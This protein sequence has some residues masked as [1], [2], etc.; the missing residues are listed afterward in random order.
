MPNYSWPPM[1]SRKQIGKRYRRVDGI[2]KATGRAKY[3]SDLNKPGMLFAAM[4]TSPYA[5]AKVRS[6]DTSQ[7]EKMPGVTAVRVVAPAGTELQWVSQE[8]A[9]VSATSEE[10][11]RDAVR[12]I[13]VDYEVLP[14]VVR[15][16]D[17]SKVADRAKPAGEQVTGDPDKAFREAEVIS[18]GMYGIPV[19]THCCLEPHG[20]V[21]EWKGDQ[22]NYWPS[23]Q[24]VTNIGPD[25]AKNLGVPAT[26]V[27]VHMDHI[28]GGFGSKFP[29]DRWGV[30]CAN[31]S[32][33]SGG[34]PVKLFLD[35]ATELN[36]AGNRPSAFA[37]IRLAAKK[38]GTIIGWESSSWA[39]GGMSGG[40]MPP[41]PY[42]FVNIPNR[43]MNH[44]AVMTN[45]G[46]LR[47]WRAPNHP[48]ASFLTCSAIEDLA[49]KLGLDPM[50]V[51]AKNMQ[52]VA[53]ARRDSYLAQLKK[54][55]EMSEWSK[56]WHRRGDSGPGP[57]KRGMGIGICTW[58]GLGHASNCRVT[59]HPDGSVIVELGSQDLGTGTR[60]V[61]AQVVA[62]TLGLPLE[63]IKV[64]LGDN[65]Y[66]PSNPSGGSTTVGGVS[67]SSR[68]AAVNA[69][70]KLF[71][72][73]APALGA[74]PDQ[75]E[76]VDGKIQVKGNPS[77]NLLWGAAC[78]KLGVQSISEMGTNDPRNPRGLN[79]QGVAGIQVADV[80]VDTE[81]G[82]VTMNRMVAVQD[83]GLVINPRLAESQVYGACIMSIC[84]ALMEERIM[85]AK[86][87]RVL[88]PDMEFY[89]LAGIG[90]I[91]EIL[92]DLHIT[93]EN[94][95]RGVIGL[96]EPPTVGGIAAIANAVAN[97]IGVR[98]PTVPLT[99]NRVLA[100]LQE[101]RA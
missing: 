10:V 82:V 63:S 35:R 45:C 6:I 60:T 25:L 12:A 15:E 67:S 43:R 39:T 58:G 47:A 73:V 26:Q 8:I 4:L 91:G 57:I 79:T 70:E 85:D 52:W 50:E 75:L 22:I 46:P 88:N 42:V 38:D 17:L 53:E 89:K 101:R 86:T 29:A 68:I 27:K 28:G 13:K 24:N 20:Q 99:P 31:L 81:T 95:K 49:A 16:E 9:F 5:H 36:I 92:V 93:P 3:N 100:A 18:E 69:L 55:A 33:A 23:T 64:N 98:V 94:D 2:E 34:R 78:K 59:I 76:A 84:G 40:G 37:K 48:Q 74:Q 1:E 32:K 65:S 77:K 72:K 66:P 61:I 19:L 97:A 54:A 80:S 44:T 90:D 71:E 41:I 7:A 14:H 96:G 21:V 62:E 56:R 51:F 83:C 11:A 87:G 30:E